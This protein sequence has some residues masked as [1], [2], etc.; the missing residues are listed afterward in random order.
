MN[1]QVNDE[2]GR[3]SWWRLWGEPMAF[4]FIVAYP[5]V[6]CQL[7]LLRTRRGAGGAGRV[8]QTWYWGVGQ[9]DGLG[10]DVVLGVWGQGAAKTLEV[11][12][13]E[14]GCGERHPRHRRTSCT[15]DPSA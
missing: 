1:T 13:A 7:V 11:W 10:A 6:S 9:G 3:A 2:D 4:L 12:G 5:E 8:G 14:K 15:Y